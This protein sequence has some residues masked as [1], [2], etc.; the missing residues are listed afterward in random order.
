MKKTSIP[1]K[2]NLQEKVTDLLNAFVESMT[3]VDTKKIKKSVRQASKMVAKAVAKSLTETKANTPIKKI[4]EAKRKFSS[5]KVA[6]K[7]SV[8]NLSTLLKNK[9]AKP[10]KENSPKPAPKKIVGT[11]K[12]TESKIA[13]L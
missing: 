13:K 8:Q 2:K 11:I 7:P 12:P 1:L 5:K 4:A 6:A 9:Q 3:T 10:L